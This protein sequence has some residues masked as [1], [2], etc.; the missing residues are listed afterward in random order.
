MAQ[1]LLDWRKQ[2]E[3]KFTFDPRQSIDPQQIAVLD[4]K[5]ASEKRE[6]ERELVAG[7]NELSQLKRQAELQYFAEE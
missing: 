3:Q 5:L 4:H 6:V 1:K 2:V 7:A